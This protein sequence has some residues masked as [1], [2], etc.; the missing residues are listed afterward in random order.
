[1]SSQ[2]I[3]KIDLKMIDLD[4]IDA[5]LTGLERP[6]RVTLKSLIESRRESILS[7]R[8]RGLGYEE[9][10]IAITSAG[11]PI[12][13]S[14]LRK[15]MGPTLRRPVSVLPPATPKP[16]AVAETGSTVTARRS[17]LRSTYL[18]SD[19]IVSQE[20]TDG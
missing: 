6:T 12:T 7:A 19:P 8:K 20:K 11:C 15:Y 3:L 2:S 13:A 4:R 1:M 16:V 18:I 5:A 14:T 9:I 10:A 17:L